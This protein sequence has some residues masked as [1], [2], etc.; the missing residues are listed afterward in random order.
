[1]T[2][3]V[4]TRG[5][6]ISHPLPPLLT[7]PWVSEDPNS[8]EEILVIPSLQLV[9]LP[10]GGLKSLVLDANVIFPFNLLGWPCPPPTTTAKNSMKEEDFRTLSVLAPG[11]L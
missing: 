4:Q 9:K 6:V 3:T 7:F 10:R 2:V 11:F 5:E 8:A 1:M